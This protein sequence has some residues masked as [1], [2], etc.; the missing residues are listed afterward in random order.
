MTVEQ[1][2][3]AVLAVLTSPV[4]LR[5]ITAVSAPAANNPGAG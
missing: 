1:A 3:S 2:A 5:E 4:W